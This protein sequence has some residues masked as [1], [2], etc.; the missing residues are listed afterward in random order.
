MPPLPAFVNGAYQSQSI[1]AAAD[2][3]INLY[4]EGLENSGE[5]KAGSALYPTPGLEVFVTLPTGPVDA[6]FAQNGRFFALAGTGFYEVFGNQTFILRGVVATNPSQP[7]M[8]SNGTAGGQLFVVS[9]GNGYILTLATNAFV[10]ITDPDFPTGQAV[11]GRFVDSYFIV[12]RQGTTEWRVSDLLNGLSWAGAMVAQ[13][14]FASDIIAA[15]AVTHREVWLLGTQTT[16]V[17]YNS[18]ASF[19]FQPITGVFLEEG[20]GAADS[21]VNLDNTLYWLSENVNGARKILRAAGGYQPQRISTHAIEFALQGYSTVADARGYGYQDQGHSFYVLTIPSQNVTWVFDSITGLWH[22]RA[23]WDS[24]VGDY[25]TQRPQCHAYAFGLHLVGDRQSGVIYRQDISLPSDGGGV[26][27]RQRT[28]VHLTD[29]LR[30]AFFSR[31]TLDL[32]TGLGTPSGQGMNPQVMM[33]WSN[34]GARTF[35][36]ERWV[37]AGLQGQYSRRATWTRLGRGRDRVFEIAMSDP[38]PWRLSNLYLHLRPG[39]S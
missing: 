25:I 23:A 1:T 34:D 7:T 11:Q 10:Q 33:R 14:S 35:G 19:P 37:G 2:R 26:I 12:L 29:E 32:E 8:S 16:E 36:P 3:C 30:W 17:W 38:I 31:L 28:M 20:C 18:G 39:N 22:E 4:P 24:V 13:R 15:L 21:V 27:R 6:V 5:V 9:G